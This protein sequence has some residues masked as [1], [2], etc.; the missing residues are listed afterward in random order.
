C[1]VENYDAHFRT[2]RL[3]SPQNWPR[4]RYR[5]LDC[6]NWRLETCLSPFPVVG[7]GLWQAD[8]S[9]NAAGELMRHLVERGGTEV[10]RGNERKDGR[11]GF[12]GAVHIANVDFVQGRL[13]H[14]ENQRTFFFEAD[15]GGTLNQVR[16]DAVGNAGEGAHAARDNDHGVGGIRTAGYV[17]TDVSVGLLMNFA[18][19]A[20]A[21]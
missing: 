3:T 21:S 17:C 16:R 13:A 5:R 8:V 10:E 7:V 9:E 4:K 12:G 6:R 11:S 20:S 18:R 15:I 19:N 14:A 1:P 2:S